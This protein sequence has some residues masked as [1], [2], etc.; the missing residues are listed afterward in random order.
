MQF[1]LTELM[2]SWPYDGEEMR[3]N[4]RRL[5]A[6]DGREILQVREPLGIQQMEYAGRPDGFRPQGMA[7]WLEYYQDQARITPGFSLGHED[8]VRLMQEGILF[9]QR[10]LILY[11]MEDWL[12]V[13]RDTD[14]NLQYFDFTG[15]HAENQ[16]DALT[17][18]QYRPYLLRMNAVGKAQI[19]RENASHERAIE[20]LELTL[21]KIRTLDPV[22]SPVF[23]MESDKAVKHLGQ[24]IAELR[25]TQPENELERLQRMKQEAVRREDFEAAARLRDQIQMLESGTASTN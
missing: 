13:V 5:K 25:K 2:K 7:T 8:C 17:L 18:E 6:E 11:Q 14:R 21:A 4:F 1:D 19:L 24:F 15:E 16:E 20:L 3:N 22:N 10:Y 23:K 12:G 9:Y